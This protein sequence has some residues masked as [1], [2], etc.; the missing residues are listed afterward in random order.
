MAAPTYEG[1]VGDLVDALA[2]SRVW[3]RGGDFRG[4]VGVA[5]RRWRWQFSRRAEDWLL[6]RRWT[7]LG[8][9]GRVQLD[10][11]Y[12]SDDCLTSSI[13]AH[14]C[15][16]NWSRVVGANPM[17][18]NDITWVLWGMPDTSVDAAPRGGW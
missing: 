4:C 1:G 18:S 17:G 13:V 16:R 8:L 10:L 11:A 7:L 6:S 2:L 14:L 12:S 3:E 15:L 9:Q 5:R